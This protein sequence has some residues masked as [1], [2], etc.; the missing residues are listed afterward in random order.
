MPLRVSWLTSK[1]RSK[2]SQGNVEKARRKTMQ[3]RLSSTQMNDGKHNQH[4]INTGRI[5]ST[6]HFR[7]RRLCVSAGRLDWSNN[8]I[9]ERSNNMISEPSSRVRRKPVTGSRALF[10]NANFF[11]PKLGVRRDDL[12][13]HPRLLHFPLLLLPPLLPGLELPA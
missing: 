2:T 5:N 12:I 11:V 7:L 4:R 13:V 6:A 1:L 9:S 10:H 3:N 8:M